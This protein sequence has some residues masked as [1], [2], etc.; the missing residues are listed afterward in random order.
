MYIYEL[1]NNLYFNLAENEKAELITL[2]NKAYKIQSFYKNDSANADF[3]N[4]VELLKTCYFVDFMDYASESIINA[5]VVILEN[6]YD[7]F[8]HNN[9]EFLFDFYCALDGYKDYISVLSDEWD[10]E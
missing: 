10:Y 1:N 6:Y 7:T 5:L 2:L 3:Y 9:Y 4:A 8:A